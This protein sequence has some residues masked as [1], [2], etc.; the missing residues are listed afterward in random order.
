M[1]VDRLTA[2]LSREQTPAPLKY[3]LS[4]LGL[5]SPRLRLPLVELADSAKADVAAAMRI[6]EED[7]KLSPVNGFA[8]G[9]QPPDS[10]H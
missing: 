2:T 1:R 6:I 8:P 5:M 4:L 10:I 9:I 3:A 7:D